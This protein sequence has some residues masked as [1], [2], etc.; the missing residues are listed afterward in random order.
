[1]ITVLG[2]KPILLWVKDKN[3]RDFG[4]FKDPVGTAVKLFLSKRSSCNVIKN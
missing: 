1:M 2:H 3:F 4:P